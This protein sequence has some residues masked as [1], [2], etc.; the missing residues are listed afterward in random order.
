MSGV[1]LP[2]GSIGTLTVDVNQRLAPDDF[3]EDGTAWEEL[4]TV[5][6]DPSGDGSLTVT[7]SGSATGYVIADAVKVSPVY[8]PEIDV[9][10][11]NDDSSQTL[12]NIGDV[13]DFGTALQHSGYP[14]NPAVG[15]K[16]FVLTNRGE[17]AMQVSNLAS[18]LDIYFPIVDDDVNDGVDKFW[19]GSAW[20][21]SAALGPQESVSVFVAQDTSAITAAGVVGSTISFS[22]SDIDE[23]NFQFQ[24]TGSVIGNYQIVDNDDADFT[25]GNFRLSTNDS[26]FY[27]RDYR[28]QFP[29]RAGVVTWSFD[30]EQAGTAQVSA[31]WFTWQNRPTNV[32]YRV[33][34]ASDPGNYLL[35]ASVNQRLAPA[36]GPQPGFQTL[37]DITSGDNEFF[38]PA[39]ETVVVS[40][41][42]TT[43]TNGYAIADAMRFDFAPGSS[44]HAV[45]EGDL[46]VAAGGSVGRPATTLGPATALDSALDQAVSWWA[47][48][49]ATA[50]ELAQLGQVQAQVMDLPGTYIGWA[51][52]TS[53]QIWIDSDAAGHGWHYEVQRTKDKGQSAHGAAVLD[54]NIPT[55]QHSNTPFSSGMDLVTALAHELGHVL[56]RDHDGDHDVMS[57]TLGAGDRLSV[58]SDQS[59]VIGDQ[60]SGIRGQGSGIEDVWS[61]FGD[62][63]GSHRESRIRGTHVSGSLESGVPASAGRTDPAFRIPNSEFR[64][65]DA[66]FARL[67]DRAGAMTDDYN[68]FNDEDD[69]SEEAE[70]GLDLWSLL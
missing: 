11:Q 66:L 55:L 23:S 43:S 38:V 36:G 31:S 58:I 54:S 29:Q 52:A 70:D 61:M 13:V 45:G 34:L 28:W 7:L 18:T 12:V 26:R 14:T 47:N 63:D 6:L 4:A 10:L 62:F 46:S 32:N 27:Q 44:L 49:G 41:M 59:S 53:P 35:T 40:L 39:G 25:Q 68:S 33:Y 1:V 5:T 65:R 3:N 9:Q 30:T 57:G 51:S 48:A 8:L 19:D 64:T 15:G 60:G 20:V 56:G 37:V 42:T 2:D 50:A 69:S 24:A 16:E 17:F 67:D 21:T 22:T